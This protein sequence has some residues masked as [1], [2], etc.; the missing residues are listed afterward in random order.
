MMGMQGALG[1]TD[2]NWWLN[3]GVKVNQPVQHT[4]T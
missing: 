2:R 4:N 3:N 1:I